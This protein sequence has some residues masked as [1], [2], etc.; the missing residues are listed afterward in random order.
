MSLF[1]TLVFIAGCKSSLTN[2]GDVGKEAHGKLNSTCR[3]PFTLDGKY[4]YTCTWDYSHL[5]GNNPWC[6]VDIDDKDNDGE[7]FWGI[8]D[9]T[10]ACNIPPRCKF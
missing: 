5:T 1:S 8:C 9:D 10:D 6:A 7:I 3:F 2:K 4:Y